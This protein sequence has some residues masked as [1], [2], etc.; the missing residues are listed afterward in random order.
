MLLM[1][2]TQ[3]GSDLRLEEKREEPQY[4]VTRH[5]KGA[6]NRRC[7]WKYLFAEISINKCIRGS[8]QTFSMSGC[9][10]LTVLNF[11]KIE[12]IHNTT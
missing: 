3:T 11:S 10:V 1:A 7:L 4:A 5:G 12:H 8:I 6:D 2:A 9:D